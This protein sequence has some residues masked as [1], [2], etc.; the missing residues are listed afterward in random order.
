VDPKIRSVL[1]PL[2]EMAAQLGNARLLNMIALGAWI[3]ALN[4]LPLV[5]VQEA[6]GRVISSHYAKLIPANAAALALGYDF[7]AA[8][9][10][11]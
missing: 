9:A 1:V 4:A 3:C 11:R 7:A 10:A 2:N 5:A 8:Y 6:L